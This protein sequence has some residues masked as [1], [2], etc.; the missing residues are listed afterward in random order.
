ME[1]AKNMSLADIWARQLY[2]LSLKWLFLI[3]CC[4]MVAAAHI[5]HAANLKGKVFDFI[6]QCHHC[7]FVHHLYRSYS[8]YKYFQQK[9]CL[10][11]LNRSQATNAMLH[12]YLSTCPECFFLFTLLTGVLVKPGIIFRL[13]MSFSCGENWRVKHSN[14]VHLNG[15]VAYSPSLSKVGG[16]KVEIC[17]DCTSRK[18]HLAA[19]PGSPY[20]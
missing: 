9:N 16:S 5:A 7:S 3:C 1:R 13:G 12:A 4:Q 11:F 18:A 19:H 8:T 6:I 20:Y 10:F 14:C 15:G 17:S 2:S